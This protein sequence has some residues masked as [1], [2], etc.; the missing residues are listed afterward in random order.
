MAYKGP[1]TPKLPTAHKL[2]AKTM[3]PTPPQPASQTQ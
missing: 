3:T 2:P 1:A